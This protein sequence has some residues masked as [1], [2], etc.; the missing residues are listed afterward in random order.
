[1]IVARVLV[2]VLAILVVAGCGDGGD[3]PE[4]EA[5]A[6]AETTPGS[7]PASEPEFEP[8]VYQDDFAASIKPIIEESCSGCHLP[9]GPGASHV[10]MATA[11]EVKDSRSAD[12]CSGVGGAMPP[13][14]AGGDSPQFLGD[15]TPAR[16]PDPG[17][18]STGPR[19]E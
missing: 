15:R 16:R 13:W 12:R 14:P 5:P 18:R 9:G 3:E 4:A 8:V 1:M 19:P 2:V 7:E 17:D 10:S 11:G 6:T